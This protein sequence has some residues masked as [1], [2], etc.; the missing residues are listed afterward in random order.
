[1][2]GTYLYKSKI[3]QCGF[4][5]HQQQLLQVQTIFSE[6]NNGNQ[7]KNSIKSILAIFWALVL[8]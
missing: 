4:K 7:N 5:R 8:I 6:T 1:M 2:I 3:K